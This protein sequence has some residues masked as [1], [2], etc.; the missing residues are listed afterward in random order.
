MQQ[1]LPLTLTSAEGVLECDLRRLPC[2]GRV[3]SGRPCVRSTRG[4]AA[5][6]A[7]FIKFT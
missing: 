7:F 4:W 6:V 1:F 3:V 5:D 2:G